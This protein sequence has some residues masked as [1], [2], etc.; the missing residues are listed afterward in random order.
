MNRDVE[1]WTVT[2]RAVAS[3][4]GVVAAQHK[5]AAR[6]GAGM[7]ADGGNAVD[8]AVA[9]ALAL[10]VVEPWM[11]GL[12]GSGY[13]VVWLAE[14]K[15]A[16]V[17]DFQGMLPAAISGD[18]Y[19]LDPDVPWSIMGFPGVID[20]QNEMGYRSI[21][22]PG[23]VMGLARA[24]ELYGR[25]GLDRVLSPAI[26]LSERGLPSSW[27]T[28][29]QTAL[30]MAD[31]RR[32]SAAS[33]IYLPNGAPPQPEQFLPLGNLSQTLCTLADEG[34]DSFYRGR[35]A[36]SMASDLKA[37]GSR[38]DGDDLA[39][40]N[41]LESEA[42]SAD[43]RHA[44]LHTAGPTSGGPRLID[45]LDH[46]GR[47]LQPEIG[48][49]P[50]SWKIYA[51]ALNQ[52]WRK[53]KQRL[54]RVT[55]VGSCTSH[56]SV[57]DADGNMVALTFTLLNRFGSC[58]VLPSTGILM[59]NAVSYF[60][61]RP[62]FPTSMEGRK[63]INA[64]NMCPTIATRDGEA[65]FALG[66]SGANHIMP[67]TT[68]IA[69][70]MLDFGMTLEEAMNHP[71]IDASD[72]GSIRVDPRLGDDVLGALSQEF[73]LEVAQLLVFPKLYS[74]P[75]GVSRDP[76]SGLCHGLN[77]P[78]QPIGGAAAAAPFELQEEEA[79]GGPRA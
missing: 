79:R 52:A 66:A 36:D 71:R 40:Y 42:L 32:D 47:H 37:G 21:S 69:A 1:Q 73:E 49:G 61:P 46:I 15:Q 12:G 30:A 51:D 72:R 25:F 41:L 3:T 16:R 9:A 10:G 8:A 4:A 55:E 29:L 45:T 59:N 7:L 62:G 22:V 53:H 76:L 20:R 27:F 17:I 35:L 54:G 58:V 14:K 26:A 56:L 74:C 5:L 11:C 33:A 6:A 75:S 34:P 48:V 68:Q 78:S 60:D 39:A 23:A 31:L 64:S 2:K 70:L 67:C 19:P 13:I 18:D 28:T 50:Q 65:I 63:R 77:D 38:I 43:Y 24:L 44:S 57:V